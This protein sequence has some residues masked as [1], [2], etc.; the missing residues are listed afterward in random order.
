ME[1]RKPLKI[2][3]LFA[4]LTI[5]SLLAGGRAAGETNDAGAVYLPLVQKK[6]LDE[7]VLVPAG[8]LQMGCDPAHNVGYSCDPDELPLHTV[9]LDA[10]QID[11]YEVTNA[12][13]A[14]CVT[15]GNCNPPRYNS[16]HNRSSYYDN[17]TYADYPVI[18]VSWLDA[19]DYCTWAGKRL[20]TEAEWEKAARGITVR[21]FPWGD[22]SPDCTLANFH[23][24]V[25]DTSQVGSY[26]LGA[27]PYGALDM[28]GNVWEWVND[29]Y[30]GGYYS[31]SPYS[32]PPGPDTGLHRVLRGADWGN[33]GTAYSLRVA[34]R[35]WL[36]A[37]TDTG[38]HIGFRCAALPG[39]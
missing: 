33:D 26:P 7:M 12:L 9:Y 20:P 11:T 38:Q 3:N 8:E 18:Y 13:Y 15:V 34:Y 29:W 30:A 32:N 23:Y 35:N 14:Q 16:S 4:L 6:P 39:R 36:P 31:V 19:T 17:P 25:G 2:Y 10:Y 28:A 21:A 24:C 22:Q 1:H 5:L 37:P 27:S